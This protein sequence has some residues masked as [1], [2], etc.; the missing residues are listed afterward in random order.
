MV[1]CHIV[2]SLSHVINNVEVVLTALLCHVIGLGLGTQ[3]GVYRWGRSTLFPIRHPAQHDETEQDV[4]NNL[5]VD[6]SG[7]NG[8]DD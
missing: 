8:N 2:N 1:I 4:C 3:A 6:A 7:D 5:H